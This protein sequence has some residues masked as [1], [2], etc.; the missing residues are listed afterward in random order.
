MSGDE[1][2]D[3]YCMS[4]SDYP[5]FTVTVAMIATVVAGPLQSQSTWQ[6]GRGLVLIERVGY[7]HVVV[8]EERVGG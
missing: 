1:C 2:I 4:D 3:G 8:Q 5:S 6:S 7:E